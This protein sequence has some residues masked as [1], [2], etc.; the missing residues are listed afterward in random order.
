MSFPKKSV[1]LEVVLEVRQQ[2]LELM[3]PA[4][5]HVR[6]E[7]IERKRQSICNRDARDPCSAGASVPLERG[8]RG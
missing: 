4:V 8:Q 1:V 3:F 6:E 2:L 7:L 5:V